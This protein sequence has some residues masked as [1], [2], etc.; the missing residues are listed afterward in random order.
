MVST[1]DF[2]YHGDHLVCSQ[3]KVLRRSTFHRRSRTFEYVARQ[4]DCQSCPVKDTCLPPRRKRRYL[5]LTMY[6]PVY[7]KARERNLTA[8]YKRER[9]R[10]QTVAK[11]TF[12]SLDRL[13]WAQSRPRG[14]W[15]V[16]CE[17]YMA[18]LAH[19]VLKMVRK[20]SHGV[21]PP[22]PGLPAMS[23]TAGTGRTLADAVRD[24]PNH[25]GVFRPKWAG[26][27]S[28]AYF[29]SGFLS[30][31]RLFQQPHPLT[32]LLES[33]GH[34]GR[35]GVSDRTEGSHRQRREQLSCLFITRCS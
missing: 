26:N 34:L 4:K 31:R 11:G 28:Q 35:V 23:A 5:S 21:G 7:L 9:R 17:G 30:P 33:H 14:W 25:H 2:A 19:N 1:G 15:K 24:A 13:S 3:G 12:A 29:P 18:T 20:L 22:G 8:A 32:P 27:R 16:D 10:R 6:H